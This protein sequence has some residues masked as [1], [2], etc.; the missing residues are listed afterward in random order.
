MIF[1]LEKYF[2]DLCTSR[3]RCVFIS[4][5]KFIYRT[6]CRRKYALDIFLVFSLGT[7]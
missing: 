5:N 3:K 4:F 6:E 2:L 7:Y 1:V